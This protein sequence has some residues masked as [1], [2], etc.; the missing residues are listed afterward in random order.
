MF[1][2]LLTTCGLLHKLISFS[3]TIQSEILFSNGRRKIAR[4]AASCLTCWE[5][6]G[7]EEGSGCLVLPLLMYHSSV[8]V[9]CNLQT[10]KTQD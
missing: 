4:A 2:V 5:T 7:W 10:D 9:R 3:V 8:L 1:S 6:S